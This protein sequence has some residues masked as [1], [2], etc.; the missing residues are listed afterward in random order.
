M[1]TKL[2][3]PKKLT[4][5]ESIALTYQQL[6]AKHGCAVDQIWN[7]HKAGFFLQPK[8]CEMA[9][10][11]RKCDLK[12][13]PT[14]VGV[15]GARAGGKSAW[16][17]A[18]IALDDCQRYPGLKFL[19][20][21]KSAAAAREQIRDLLI[22][23]CPKG[24]VDYNYREQA[25]IIQFTNGSFI[26]IKHFK[27]EKDITDFLGQEYDGI[28]IEELTTLTSEK[29]ENLMTCLRTSKEGWRPRFYGAWNWGGLGHQWVMK[30]FYV[31]WE[32]KRQTNTF[33][34][35]ATIHDNAHV[36]EENKKMLSELPSS[37]WKYKSWY[38]GDPHFQ[39][40]Q[41]FTT[42]DESFHVLDAFDERTIVKWYGGFDYGWTHPTAFILAG[43][44]RQGNLIMLEEHGMAQTI[45]SE[46]CQYIYSMLSKRNM[47]P[48]DLD[49]IAAGRDCFSAKEDGTTISDTYSANG[50]NLTPAE[51]D[52]INGWAKFVARLGEPNKG[53]KPTMFI[54]RR[55]KNLI[56]QIPLAQHHEKRPED[57]EKMNASADGDG[58]DGDDF[59]ETA[60]NIISSNPFHGIKF[61][62]PIGITKFGVRRL[63]VASF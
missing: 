62:A 43:E 58:S 26:I 48:S 12:D 31:P 42:W 13:G 2:P 53:F 61:I 54:H 18:Q 39:A 24:L 32:E 33:Y 38:L 10:A 59:L 35:K 17:F 50:I 44:D 51:V 28:G 46:H 30:K 37:S 57:I 29:F 56:A 34:V 8:Q 60:R 14:M 41:F 49:Y 23:T 7:Y 5:D 19:Y 16:L 52:R 63:S 15:G 3:K 55:C 20:L 21:R 27:D 25:G 22:K 45:I 36:N 6:G 1:P 47:R 40:G 9:A 11:A 4:Q